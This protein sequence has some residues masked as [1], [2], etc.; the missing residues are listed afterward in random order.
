MLDF[1][2]DLAWISSLEIQTTIQ[3]DFMQNPGGFHKKFRWISCKIQV[4]L[5]KNS[6]AFKANPGGFHWILRVI[7]LDFSLEIYAKSVTNPCQIH[8]EIQHGYMLE[9]Y[10]PSHQNVLQLLQV[11]SP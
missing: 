10:A 2:V 9:V 4:D 1:H 5:V 7:H 3:M 11:W 8:M 6:D